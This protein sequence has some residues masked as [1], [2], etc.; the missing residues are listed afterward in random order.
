MAALGLHAV[1]SKLKRKETVPIRRG[2]GSKL[3]E[4]HNFSKARH[5]ART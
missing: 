1:L 3:G 2:G 5:Q 4:D